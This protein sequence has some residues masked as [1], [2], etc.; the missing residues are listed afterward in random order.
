MYPAVGD[1]LE[2]TVERYPDRDAIV[3]PRREQRWTY[4]EFNERVN[5]FANSLSDLGVRKGDRVA[6]VLYNGSEMAVAVYACAKLGAVFTPLN[7]RLPGGEIEYIVNDAEARTLVFEAETRDAVENAKPDLTTV[8][9]YIY[10]DED[11]PEY[12]HDFYALVENGDRSRP[13]TVVT[14]DDVYAFIYPSGTTGQ[15]KGVVHEHRSMVEHSLI[16]IAEL[17]ITHQDIGLSI[18]P[19]YHCA[20]LHIMLFGRVHRGATNVIHHEFDPS[21][22]LRA[23]ADHRITLL[24]AAPTAWNALAQTAKEMPVDTSSLRLGFYG[25][26]PMPKRVLDDCMELFC[27]NF[28]Q[29]YGM[30][31]IGPAGVFQPAEDQISKQGCAGLPALNHELRIVSPGAD[32]EEEIDT[33]EI[34]EILIAGPCTMREYWNRPDATA[35]SLRESNGTEWYYTGD[36]GYLDDD[37]YLWVVD[38]KDDMIIS[39]GENIYP[40]E[41]EDVIFSH[42]GVTEAAVVGEPDDEWGERVV[43]Y[44][45]GDASPND[46]DEHMR[47]S[48]TLADFKRP[49][50]YYEIDSLPK[51]PSGKVQKFKLQE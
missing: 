24:F 30:T 6:T 2:Q 29:A 31:E 35:R 19:L 10:I 20:E 37:G 42:S 49:R 16:C 43:A 15:P 11:T 28:V 46:L 51:N 17:N 26:A 45:V 1:T 14:E 4:E 40:T 48:E 5:R 47:D 18:L 7:F 50:E 38:R 25:A 8:E 3:Y 21:E 23:I 32:P 41:V 9:N 12:A 13:E 34:G 33:G 22:A 39:G 44:I 36:L 27:E